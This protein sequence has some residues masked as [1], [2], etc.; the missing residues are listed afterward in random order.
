M[1]KKAKKKNQDFFQVYGINGVSNIIQAKKINIR[2]SINSVNLEKVL[3]FFLCLLY[4][5][6]RYLYE[7]EFTSIHG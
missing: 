5:K 3:I 6:I 7:M 1:V 2:N 4:H